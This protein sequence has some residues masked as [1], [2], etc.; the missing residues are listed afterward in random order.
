MRIAHRC[1]SALR[2]RCSP[3]RNLAILIIRLNG[4]KSIAADLRWVA[5]DY[6]TTLAVIG[7]QRLQ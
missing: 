4:F 2:L 6:T 5:W 7:L 3:L 1:E